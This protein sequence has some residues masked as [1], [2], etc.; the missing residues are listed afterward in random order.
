MAGSEP[1]PDEGAAAAAEE[2]AARHASGNS[3]PKDGSTT[4]FRFHGTAQ[5]GTPPAMPVEISN[6]IPAQTRA[7]LYH[8]RW[9]STHAA[10]V[11]ALWPHVFLQTT[12]FQITLYLQLDSGSAHL[13]G[14]CICH[15]P[16]SGG[17]HPVGAPA[18]PLGG[19]RAGCQC[20]PRDRHIGR[21]L[22]RT[23][24][25]RQQPSWLCSGLLRSAHQLWRI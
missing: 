22:R 11:L 18:G 7:D 2:A 14:V 23:T 16:H 21:G 25:A 9:V 20:A 5:R 13:Q 6:E 24:A 12:S 15:H 4:G 8:T 10:L 3:A 17:G 1:S 19:R